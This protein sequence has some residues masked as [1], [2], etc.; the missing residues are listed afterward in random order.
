MKKWPRYNAQKEYID[1]YIAWPKKF[2][3]RMRPRNVSEETTSI[4][5]SVQRIPSNELSMK[6]N[7]A[8]L[9]R[10]KPLLPPCDCR[11]KCYE[12]LCEST[13]QAVNTKYW[14][15]GYESR[16]SF[17]KQSIL[18]ETPKR[19]SINIG[20]LA[21][22]EKTVTRTYTIAQTIVCKVF[23]MHTLGY[24]ADKFIT[25]ALKENNDSVL[26]ETAVGKG[27]YDHKVSHGISGDDEAFM[28][29][30]ITSKYHPGISHYRREHAPHRLYVDPSVRIF[31][32]YETSK[33]ECAKEQRRC[34][35]M[36]T[37]MKK[38]HKMNIS[39]AKLGQ[40][41][42]E[43]CLAHKHH[44]C[45][46]GVC[47]VCIAFNK[48]INKNYLA[49][50][51]YKNDK[52][53]SEAS[54]K[55]NGLASKILYFSTDLQKVR[56]IP[57][58]PGSKLTCFMQRICGYNETF[59]PIGKSF[60]KSWACI[61]HQ[62]VQGRN[63][64][65]I[66]SAFVKFIQQHRDLEHLVLWMDNCTSQNKNWTL[67]STLAKVMSAPTYSVSSLQTITLKYFEKGHSYMSADSF[68]HRVEKQSKIMK[69]L[70]DYDDYVECI[71]RV[72]NA[73]L[74]EPADFRDWSKD[75]SYGKV[76][77][78]TRTILQSVSVIQF[79]KGDPCM[80]FKNNFEEK[81]FSKTDFLKK[82][83]KET[84]SAVFSGEESHSGLI[85]KVCRIK[86]IDKDKKQGIL[87]NLCPLMPANRRKFWENI[88]TK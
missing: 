56:M 18:Q 32:I 38:I 43:T 40:E 47:D 13:R 3:K 82:K 78:E 73:I 65:D 53:L 20:E 4:A 7:A 16:R 50:N 15:M 46:D 12:K 84:M 26:E 68:H 85:P 86:G 58:I 45:Q 27:N 1:S 72:G 8:D 35:A 66:T 52:E 2:T 23:F 57:D 36:S 64:E 34:F 59:S 69:N 28:E 33:Q 6:S 37:F 83:T 63:D 42:C 17:V 11:L 30:I 39:F 55:N 75:I 80:Y 25:V 49:R 19:K 9:Y 48:H 70:Y 76:S 87:M 10:H 81:E 51:A 22:K 88:V 14:A 67:L 31:S 60:G 29:F 71:R 41:E 44:V 54:Y 74:M 77:K 62:G 24:T 61:W 79:R 5:S 21:R